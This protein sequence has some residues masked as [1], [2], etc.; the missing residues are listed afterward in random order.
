MR[1]SRSA[2]LVLCS[3]EASQVDRSRHGL[4]H[5]VVGWTLPRGIEAMR[6]KGARLCGNA[7]RSSVFISI[8]PPPPPLALH[9]IINIAMSTPTPSPS[10]ALFLSCVYSHCF[11]FSSDYSLHDSSSYL[12]RLQ[13]SASMRLLFILPLLPN[14]TPPTTPTPYY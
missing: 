2:F 8:V 13:Q 7:Y 6:T 4:G 3:S 11:C 14:P 12:P 10:V 9:S 1:A 5:L